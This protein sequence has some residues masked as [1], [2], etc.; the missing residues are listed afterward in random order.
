MPR[1]HV[2]LELGGN[3]AAVVCPDWD[4]LDFAA[5]RIATFVMY[6]GGQSCIS[7]QRVYAHADIYPALAETVVAHVR[8][9]GVGAPTDPATDVGPLIK[10]A[11]VVALNLSADLRSLGEESESAVWHAYT[12]E[13][14]RRVL[15]E[16]CP[17]VIAAIQYV[18]V[19][20][21]ADTMQF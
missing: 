21:D 3:V 13:G 1:K 19:N 7:V 2:V 17:A 14:A 11:A 20:C 6:Q 4:D 12:V 15:G 10:Q 18:R 5:S 8:K 16:E 9:L